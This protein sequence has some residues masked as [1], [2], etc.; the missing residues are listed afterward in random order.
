MSSSAG[1][2]VSPVD[3]AAQ[4]RRELRG[5]IAALRTRLATLERRARAVR[6]RTEQVHGD[7]ASEDNTV[8]ENTVERLRDAI[9]SAQSRISDAWTSR[10][11]EEIAAVAPAERAR[12][13]SATAELHDSRQRQQPADTGA[14]RRRA[15]IDDVA[16]LMRSA[17]PRCE[18]ADLA[19]LS[20]KL[21]EMSTMDNLGAVR[22]AALDLSVTIRDAVERH[23]IRDAG[24]ELRSRLLDLL[25][26]ALPADQDR[27][28]TEI[29]SADDCRPL[30]DRVHQAVERAD[31]RKHQDVMV[32][33]VADALTEAGCVV[34][35][36]FSGMLLAHG[37][38]VA[39]LRE[40]D[41]DYGL[42]VRL[43]ADGGKVLTSVVRGE[44]LPPDPAHDVRVQ[45]TFC[46]ATLPAITASLAERVTVDPHPFLMI[47][48]GR[49]PMAA[50][51]LPSTR[52][53]RSPAKPAVAQTLRE[54]GR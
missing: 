29:E 23:K 9:S 49:M 25:G 44:D 28:R 41:D 26:E 40:P 43:P 34:D 13:R 16:R 39:G 37:E 45:Q 46:A 52:R 11:Q 54:R 30:R 6:V 36:A 42:L 21:A 1:Y 51:P 10:W 14:T 2:Y 32:Q 53:R 18:P 24:D 35:K 12:S 19:E 47:D 7:D 20:G 33:A 3:L 50:A 48:P 4:R 8:L 17:G 38:A 31:L 22:A 27:L 15:A 5:E